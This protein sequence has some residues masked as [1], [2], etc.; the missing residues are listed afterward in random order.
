MLY[1]YTDLYYSGKKLNDKMGNKKYQIGLGIIG[2]F[3]SLIYVLS[4]L[5]LWMGVFNI[6]E[7][8]NICTTGNDLREGIKLISVNLYQYGLAVFIP[9]SFFEIYN[10]PHRRSNA[11][12]AIA[13]SANTEEQE[14]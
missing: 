3:I 2:I 10:K 4:C 8:V 13:E 11:Q 12:L 7:G 14:D 6:K 9:L 5:L 1:D